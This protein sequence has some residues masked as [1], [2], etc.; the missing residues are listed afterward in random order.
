MFFVLSGFLI[1]RSAARAES[2]GR[3]L[4]HRFLRVVPGYWVCLALCAFGVAPLVCL[5]EHGAIA[6]LF[7]A[8]DAP[9]NYFFG[10]FLLFHAAAPSIL[11]VMNLHPVSVGGLFEAN[12]Y[13]YFFNGS[14]WTLP[15]EGL[16]Y[17]TLASV[18]ALRLPF[19]RRRLLLAG[20][21]I[22]WFLHAFEWLA[23]VAFRQCFPS[24]ALGLLVMLAMYFVAGTLAYLYRSEIKYPRTLLIVSAA[25]LFA[26]LGG[27]CFG[28]VAPLAIPYLF[29]WTACKLPLQRF[30][31][32]GDFSYG[33]YIYAFPVQQILALLHVQTGGL[34]LFFIW[35]ILLSAILAILSYRL[36][37]APCLRLKDANLARWKNGG[38]PRT[39][40]NR[41]QAA[42]V[43]WTAG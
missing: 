17:I 6:P 41:A 1:A 30:D 38:R 18:A 28:V 12:P 4:W 14:L 19:H 36:V 2:I 34:G 10:N 33:L 37:E 24:P 23:P 22:L 29:L 31:A 9:Q 21:G 27:G 13:R 32:R 26:S 16:F 43:S 25:A 8:V 3:F 35:S 39:R 20:F 42:D 40:T 7:R 15:F 11:G 5:Y